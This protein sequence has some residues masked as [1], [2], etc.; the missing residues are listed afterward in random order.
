M[1]TFEQHIFIDC[2]KDNVYDHIAQ[3]LNMIGLQSLLTTIDVSKEQKDEQGIVLRPFYT[4]EVFRWAG[5]PLM[6]NRIYSVIHLTKPRD[7]LEFHVYSKPNIKIVF[8]YKFI[9]SNDQRTHLTQTINFERVPRLVEGF[10][11]DQA[12]K[13]Q[14]ALL[15]NLKVRLEKS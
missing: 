12:V 11:F 5:I 2:Q 7:E 3:P 15:T 8:Q 10:V 14:R 9:Q 4:V 6:R 13:A 1:R